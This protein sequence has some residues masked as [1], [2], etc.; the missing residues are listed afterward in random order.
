MRA[1]NRR[2]NRPIPRR[3]AERDALPGRV[4]WVPAGDD[5]LRPGGVGLERSEQFRIRSEDAASGRRFVTRTTCGEGKGGDD[6]PRGPSI[7]LDP[8]STTA[9]P[10][11]PTTNPERHRP[12]YQI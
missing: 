1:R 11:G 5:R 3:R 8:K 10:H 7:H 4:P 6:A 9:K 12:P 2:E